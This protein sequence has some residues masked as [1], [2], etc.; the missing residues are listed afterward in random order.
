MACCPFPL[1]F[2]FLL[3]LV[4]NCYLDG[5]SSCILFLVCISHSL[6]Y[7]HFS[8]WP[9]HISPNIPI[10]QIYQHF[11]SLYIYP[12]VS[13]PFQYLVYP[14]FLVFFAEVFPARQ[15]YQNIEGYGFSL[16]YY[17]NTT[18]WMT[19]PHMLINMILLTHTNWMWSCWNETAGLFC[20]GIW[21]EQ[22]P[23][24]LLILV[25]F[26]SKQ[27]LTLKLTEDAVC[28]TSTIPTSTITN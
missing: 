10:C 2:F 24:S 8:S 25:F 20:I 23:I 3:A 5:W 17:E 14:T 7:N 6:L 15:G 9:F 21:L 1:S 11:P 28:F 22:T 26:L 12:L 16:L 19:L 4:L 27:L 18:G 13:F